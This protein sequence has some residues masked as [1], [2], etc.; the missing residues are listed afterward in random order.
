[1][2]AYIIAEVDVTDPDSYAGY[3]ELVPAT[4]E[5]YG[6]RFLVRGGPA[7]ALEGAAPKRIVIL[8]FADA[9]AAR[10]WYDSPEYRKAKAMRQAASTGRLI[11][12]EGAQ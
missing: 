9:A 6:G 1:M 5:T 2:A 3:R 10:R 12:A 8:E 4:L 7:E 11:L